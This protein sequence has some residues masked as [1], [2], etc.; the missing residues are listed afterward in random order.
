MIFIYCILLLGFSGMLYISETRGNIMTYG[1]SVW[2]TIVS[3]T[4]LGY[5]DMYPTAD[6]GRVCI[7]LCVVSATVFMAIPIGIIG[8]AFNDVWKN[9]DRI[10]LM[11]RARVGMKQAGYSAKDIKRLFK[12]F[13][14]YKNGLLN[15]KEFRL[16]LTELRLGLKQERMAELYEF[17]DD[18]N[19]GGIDEK[20]FVKGLFPESFHDLYG[21]ED[22]DE[23]DSVDAGESVS[24]PGRM[25]VVRHVS[26]SREM[27]STPP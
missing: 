25:A 18:D 5:G 17:F 21:D 19:S 13:D 27:I 11:Q 24:R 23:A 3:M 2:L 12:I 4:T 20:E 8:N 9:R 15:M 16:M 1:S 22:S 10:L 26:S 7:G 6:A 14:R